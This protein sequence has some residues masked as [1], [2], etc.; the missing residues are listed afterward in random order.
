[1]ESVHVN[2]DGKFI[3]APLTTELQ[4]LG[5]ARERADVWVLMSLRDDAPVDLKA[6]QHELARWAKCGAARAYVWVNCLIDGEPETSMASEADW[7]SV[8]PV[9]LRHGPMIQYAVR[10][11]VREAGLAET[12]VRISANMGS[13]SDWQVTATD[14]ETNAAADLLAEESSIGDERIKVY[15][16]RTALSRFSHL[17]AEFAIQ[18]IPPLEEVSLEDAE[19]MLEAAKEYLFVLRRDNK[20]YASFCW[21]ANP[22]NDEEQSEAEIEEYRQRSK[23]ILTMFHEQF[24]RR[25]PHGLKVGPCFNYEW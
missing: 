5:S 16:V 7:A 12:I 11:V 4:R 21:T 13:E 22:Q 14:F 3:V 18:M 2:R 17:G 8:R 20:I 23:Q 15:P 1:M 24:V 10:H 25:K 6:L 19:E 9:V